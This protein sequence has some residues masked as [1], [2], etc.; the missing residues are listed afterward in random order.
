MQTITLGQHHTPLRLEWRKDQLRAVV[1]VL[2]DRIGA[3]PVIS[4]MWMAIA[5]VARS[6]V[7]EHLS[8]GGALH[9]SR[10]RTAYSAIEPRYRSADPRHSFYFVRG[11]V[12]AL[13]EAGL[14][15]HNLGTWFGGE[16]PGIESTVW[17]K[18]QLIELISP[19]ITATEPLDVSE[20]S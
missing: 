11:A 1:E 7:T 20:V 8:T 12:D 2:H 18:P 15:G 10:S 19:L 13:R 16:V 3:L 4:E 17:P 14:V 6:V 5:S 9:Y